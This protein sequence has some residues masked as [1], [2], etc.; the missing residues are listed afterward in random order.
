VQRRY[1]ALRLVQDELNQALKRQR[2]QEEELGGGGP[3]GAGSAS[4]EERRAQRAQEI[5]RLSKKYEKMKPASAAGV[6]EVLMKSDEDLAV[7]IIKAIKASKAG[8]IL[9]SLKPDAAARLSE[10]MA[11]TRRR[12]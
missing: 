6:I 1:K 9:S 4:S 2:A 10:L 8:K 5:S 3:A 11:S 12:R 7:D